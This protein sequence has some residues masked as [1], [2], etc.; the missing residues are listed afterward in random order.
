[1]AVKVFIMKIYL[2]I[3]LVFSAQV[4]AAD[5]CSR[6][7]TIRYQEVLVDAGT[8]KPGEG[9]RFYLEK[10]PKSKELLDQYQE[11]NRPT[12][13]NA[14]AS[15]LGSLLIL[16]GLMQTSASDGSQNRNSLF[17]G[18][19][20]LIALSYLSTKT[21]QLSNEKLLEASIEHYNKRN[22]PRIYFYPHKDNNNS[23]GL[24]FGVQRNF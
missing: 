22:K 11:G 8:D 21:R 5:I 24:G 17:Y 2:F 15:T 7:A 9:L 3:L 23:S 18:G 16:A 13:L 4:F 12:V 14:S 19:S 6:V 1:M 10:E 20:T